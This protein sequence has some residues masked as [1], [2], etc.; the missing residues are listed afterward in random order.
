M[1]NTHAKTSCISRNMC[2]FSLGNFKEKTTCFSPRHMFSCL[3]RH[4]YLRAVCTLV[5]EILQSFFLTFKTWY[6][7]ND[8]K[9][10][11]KLHSCHGDHMFY[12]RFLHAAYVGLIFGNRCPLLAVPSLCEEWD[13]SHVI[14]DVWFLILSPIRKQILSS[15]AYD[16]ATGSS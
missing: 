2:S 6:S 16:Y 11:S 7:R 8:C 3:F 9:P 14:A 12:C 15:Y 10:Q 13:A 5:I 4:M 1:R